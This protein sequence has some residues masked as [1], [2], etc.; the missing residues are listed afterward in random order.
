[1]PQDDAIARLARQIDAT[2][3]VER[4]L[5][6]AEQ[7]ATLRR[8]GACDL[9]RVCA[10][11]VAMVNRSLSSARL[12]L[13][14][15]EYSAE[16]FR[17]SGPNLI[18]ISSQGRHIQIVFTAPAELVSTEKFLVPYVLEGDLRTYNQRML[19]RFDV[20]SLMIFFCV[21]NDTAA[22][23]SFDWRTRSTGPFTG[24]L[25]VNLMGPLF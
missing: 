7:V 18:Q 10:D 24:D 23:R 16:M 14:P 19:E 4:R 9:H 17:D 8:Q 12:D 5:A 6:S 11:F 22:W 3:N 25:L 13:S 2:H 21:E 1:M 20:R 15:P